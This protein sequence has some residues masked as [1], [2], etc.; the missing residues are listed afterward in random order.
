MM[1]VVDLQPQQIEPRV[2]GEGVLERPDLVQLEVSPQTGQAKRSSENQHH[3]GDEWQSMS[4]N[5]RPVFYRAGARTATPS[6]PGRARRSSGACCDEAPESIDR[7]I[8][9]PCH[10]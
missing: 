7:H 2:R 1:V 3:S 10:G 6:A 9:R 4:A 8:L 5:H